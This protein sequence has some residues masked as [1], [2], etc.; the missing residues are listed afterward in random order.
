MGNALSTLGLEAQATRQQRNAGN[1]VA[2]KNERGAHSNY[3]SICFRE[4]PAA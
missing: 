1:R 4:G 2:A 3:S